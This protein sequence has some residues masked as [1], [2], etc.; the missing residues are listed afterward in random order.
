MPVMAVTNQ[1]EFGT[2]YCLLLLLYRLCVLAEACICGILVSE[3]GVCRD[4]RDE[5]G[6]GGETTE[7][8]KRARMRKSK[9]KS[10]MMNGAANAELSGRDP[11]G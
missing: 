10:P 6:F 1:D 7:C 4:A 8:G 11:A 9:G 5:A 2:R 3:R